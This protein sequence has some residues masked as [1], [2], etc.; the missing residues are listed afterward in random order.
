MKNLD[1]RFVQ[2]GL[3]LDYYES[4]LSKKQFDA[5]DMYYNKDMSLSE[6][7][8]NLGITRQGV[9]EILKRSEERLFDLEE[10]LHCYELNL[11]CDKLR[12]ALL[13][14]TLLQKDEKHDEAIILAKQI[15]SE[16][17]ETV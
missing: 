12:K 14:V 13:K 11:V 7:G 3:L 15:L 4:V 1:D 8:E 9:H 16:V 6:I 2:V 10:K 5:L 17:E